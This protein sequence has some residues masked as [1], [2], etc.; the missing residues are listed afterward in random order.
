MTAALQQMDMRDGYIMRIK[1]FVNDKFHKLCADCER[2]KRRPTMAEYLRVLQMAA[3][4]A[5]DAT[6]TKRDN[7]RAGFYND[8]TGR[9]RYDARRVL[10]RRK[11]QASAAYEDG[12]YRIQDYQVSQ[13]ELEFAEIWA[14]EEEGLWAL[15][16]SFMG[17]FTPMFET[18]LPLSETKSQSLSKMGGWV[19]A[20]DSV[21]AVNHLELGRA[22][23]K[24]TKENGPARKKQKMLTT[25]RERIETMKVQVAFYRT[26]DI[27]EWD[28]KGDGTYSVLCEWAANRF[29]VVDG[30]S[31]YA[32]TMNIRVGDETIMG[33]ADTV[34]RHKEGAPRVDPLRDLTG[35]EL[36]A[37]IIAKTGQ[38]PGKNGTS[39]AAKKKY[40]DSLISFPWMEIQEIDLPP[41]AEAAAAAEAVNPDDT[42]VPEVPG[43]GGDDSDSG[44]D[45]G[46]DDDVVFVSVDDHDGRDGQD[47]QNDQDD[48][49]DAWV[50]SDNE[51]DDGVGGTDE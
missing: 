13:R 22:K 9:L 11:I 2:A 46:G 19:G 6:K 25:W 10:A 35:T 45:D 50:P 49:E 34:L 47:G 37:Y 39:V 23:K 16:G 51:D 12:S 38:G 21:A 42:P 15:H 27:L 28:K 40:A 30:A 43:G 5:H 14:K 33:I 8:E 31:V 1:K 41:G 18:P 32:G 26:G 3:T 4:E 48:Q 36:Q 7:L 20:A 29:K 24:D 17:E 44:E